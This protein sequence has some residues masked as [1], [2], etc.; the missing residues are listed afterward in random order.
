MLDIVFPAFRLQSQT[1]LYG[2][3]HWKRRRISRSPPSAGKNGDDKERTKMKKR[4]MAGLLLAGA[5]VCLRARAFVTAEKQTIDDD[6][7]YIADQGEPAERGASVYERAI[8]PGLDRAGS[9]LGLVALSPVYA[10]TA[11]AAYLDDPGPVLFKQKRVGKGK[12][13][14]FLRKFRTMKTSTPHDVPTHLLGNP[15][16]YITGIGRVLRRYSLDELPQLWDVFRGR[17][18][19]VGPR[20][21]LWNQADLVAER[22]RYGANDVTPG[23]TGWA[24]INGRDELSIEEKARYDGEYAAA[25]KAGGWTAFKMDARCLLGTFFKVLRHEGVLEGGPS[26]GK[27]PA[28]V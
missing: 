27:E 2:K 18:S 3:R 13:Y 21:A 17:L 9:F 1:W 8:K 26:A 19:L 12:R 14:F 24:Q 10:A 25:L 16:Q 5:Y 4:H 15:E 6:N 20:P 23:I 28:A 11:A 22:D 7:P